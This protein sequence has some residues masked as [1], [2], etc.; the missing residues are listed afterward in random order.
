MKMMIV[1]AAAVLLVGLAQA[2]LAGPRVQA[3]VKELTALEQKMLGTWQGQGPCDGRL[4]LRADGTYKL[5]EYGPADYDSQGAWKVR[6]EVSPATLVLICKNSEVQD[7]VGRTTEVKLVKLDDKNLA[8][9]Y[10]NRNGSPSGRYK[11]VKK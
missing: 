6:S 7:E 2:D 8:I 5:T 4:V 11:R 10:A 1:P 9:E 3:R